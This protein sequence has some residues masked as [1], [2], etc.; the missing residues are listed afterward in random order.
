MVKEELD[1]EKDR[2]P[3]RG[4]GEALE[5]CSGRRSEQGHGRIPRLLPSSVGRSEQITHWD[6]VWSGC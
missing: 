2:C 3:C 5:T 4:S 6:P 1:G